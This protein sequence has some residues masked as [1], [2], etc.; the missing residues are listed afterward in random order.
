MTFLMKKA[1]FHPLKQVECVNQW[2]VWMDDPGDCYCFKSVHILDSMYKCHYYVF[3]LQLLCV[4]HQWFGTEELCPLCS[5]NNASLQHI[6]SGC[7][8]ALSQD[9]YRWRHDLLLRKLAEVTESC[10][11]EA[12]SRPS[13]P[14]RRP[15]LFARAGENINHRHQRTTPR[16]LSSGSEW[17]MRVNLGRQLQFP[18]EIVET[19][20]QT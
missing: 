4:L 18:R 15:I 3:M 20:S 5:T 16:V 10:R 11:Q 8:T 17:N 6:L 7:K 1:M 12:N 19:T 2:D 13:A 9:R 14:T